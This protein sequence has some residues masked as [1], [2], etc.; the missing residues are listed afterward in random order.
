MEMKRYPL[1][2]T[3]HDIFE[4]VRV[5]IRNMNEKGLS[6]NYHWSRW[7][8]YFARASFDINDL[9]Q[10]VLFYDDQQLIGMLM[11]EDEKDIYYFVTDNKAVKFEIIKYLKHVP[12]ASLM[13]EDSDLE[14]IHLM[15]QYAWLKTD[16]TEH[17]ARLTTSNISYD[18]SSEYQLLCF[19]DTYDVRKHHTCLWKGFNHEGL[20]PMDQADLDD[21]QRQIESPHFK[22]RYA[23]AVAYQDEYVAYTSIW[24]EKGTKIA[25]IEPVCT[26]PN[27]RSKG[28]ATATI[29]KCVDAVIKDG[30]KHIIVGSNQEFYKAIGFEVFAYAHVYKQPKI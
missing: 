17:M 7:E 2:A 29:S 24:Y 20:P 23:Y 6:T 14:M 25:M 16:Y 12:S 27:H 8:W 15:D 5:F 1:D 21:R 26:V 11:T 4:S 10:H 30:A 19:S 22:N 3:Y 18:I 13:V 28:L 9:S